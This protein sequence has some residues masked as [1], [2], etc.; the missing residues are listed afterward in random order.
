MEAL[1]TVTSAARALGV[2]A[3]RVRAL[4][5]QGRVSGAKKYGRAWLIPS[6]IAVMPASKSCPGKIKLHGDP[7]LLP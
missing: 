5:Q 3:Q 4:C 2:C 7:Q 6:P 1:I